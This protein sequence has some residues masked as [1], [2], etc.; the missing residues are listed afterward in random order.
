MQ[1]GDDVA[2][3]QR[4]LNHLGFD[5]GRVDGIFG[6]LAAQ[7]V[8]EFQRHSGCT[9]DGICGPLTVAALDRLGRF[10]STTGIDGVREVEAL[11]HGPR[12]LGGTRWCI[13]T[14]AGSRSLARAVGQ[15]LRAAGAHAV[16]VDDP[17]P[18][19][20][21]AV[22]NAVAAAVHLDLHVEGGDPARPVPADAAAQGLTVSYYATQ[23][24]T[25][26]GGRRLAQ[27]C[28]RVLAD[29]CPA[30][31]TVGSRAPVLRETRMPAVDLLLPVTLLERPVSH[32]VVRRL[33][34]ALQRWVEHP[35]PDRE[36][37]AG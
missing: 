22:A 11:R 14:D 33:A 35:M 7:A 36:P 9:P 34:V 12:H 23:A 29:L 15:V 2:E 20:R 10:A 1:R 5:A 3:L 17:A 26:V 28:T 31:S 8:E 4:R 32:E 21:A 6:P 37:T 13:G 19:R 25:S 27:L 30:T 24:T 18:S 16:I